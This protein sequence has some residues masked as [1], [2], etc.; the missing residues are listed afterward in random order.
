MRKNAET[1]TSE[2]QL[3]IQPM[4]S[5]ALEELLTAELMRSGKLSVRKALQLIRKVDFKKALI[6]SG[7]AAAAVSVVNL[8][9]KY[10]FYNSVVSGELKK[11]LAPVNKKLDELQKQNLELQ[12][13][14]DEIN[15]VEPA[16]SVKK[17]R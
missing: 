1:K 15:G 11:Q 9:G 7:A 2:L 3:S 8:T 14:L 13:Q 6:I 17:H 16:P 12:K 10:R 4:P 5:G